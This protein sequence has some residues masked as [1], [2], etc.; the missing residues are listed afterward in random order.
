M[1]NAIAFNWF[2]HLP[3]KADRVFVA[4]L[5]YQNCRKSTHALNLPDVMCYSILCSGGSVN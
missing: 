2:D 3:N 5:T 1:K 4:T